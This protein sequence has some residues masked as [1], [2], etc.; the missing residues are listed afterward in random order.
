MKKHFFLGSGSS[1]EG[2]ESGCEHSEG[3]TGM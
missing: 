1:F 2:L 3:L